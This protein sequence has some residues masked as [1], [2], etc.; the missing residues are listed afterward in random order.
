M[1]RNPRDYKK[2]VIYCIRNHNNDKLYIGSS[3]DSI[4]K[5]MYQHKIACYD[6]NRRQNLEL[7]KD[8]REYGFNN[9]YIEEV[10]KCPCND[11]NELRRRENYYIRL[12]KTNTQG[13]NNN[14]A[15]IDTEREEEYRIIQKQKYENNK[16]D[17][18]KK[19]KDY[20]KK[21]NDKYECEICNFHTYIK[22]HYEKHIK[23]KKHI[24]KLSKSN[25]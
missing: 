16:Q 14:Y 5:R 19:M 9:Y 12:Y 3:C 7:Y 6:K 8:M 1:S 11:N 20:S 22:T 10:E 13:Y 25:I 21:N 4:Q 17:I 2:G 24:K 18:L 23:C 15:I